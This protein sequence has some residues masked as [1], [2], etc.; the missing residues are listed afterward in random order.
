[1]ND[2]GYEA[3]YAACPCFWGDKPGSLIRKLCHL[4][5]DLR[6]LRVIDAGCGEGKN[7]IAL[8]QAGC[9]VHAVD[10]S[11]QA[12]SVGVRRFFHPGITWHVADMMRWNLAPE[13]YDIVVAYGLLHCIPTSDG[14]MH[15][16]ARLQAATRPRGIN[17]I[18]AFDDGAHDLSAHPG[19]TPN[20]VA[21]K[22][23]VSFYDGWRLIMASSSRLDETHPHNRIPHYH[24]LTRILAEKV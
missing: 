14:L 15:L 19:F 23:Y 9:F 6:G 7:A 20:L 12:V 16:L 24:S 1:M 10:C 8:A 17:V 11:A 21:Y 13:R 4:G 5:R 22:D 2:G 3:G 18:C